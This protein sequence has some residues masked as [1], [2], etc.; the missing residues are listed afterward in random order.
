MSVSVEAI[1][2]GRQ[3]VQE[4]VDEGRPLPEVLETLCLEVERAAGSGVLA[5]VLL[6]DDDRLH[7][8]HGAAPSLPDAYNE[9]IDGIEIGA[10]VGSCGTAVYR[11]EPVIVTDISRDP[12]WADF[13][14]LA[15]EHGLGACWST[16]IKSS[17]GF[18]LGTFA[19]YYPEP[20]QPQPGDRAL[21]AAI[22]DIAARA[23]EQQRGD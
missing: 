9:A 6:L 10:S 11:R 4:L 22:A 17:R 8:R 23:I 14:D 21:V 1:E 12:L 2:P 18:I 13:K 15:A 7:L 20:R 16:P 3:R 5:S 19:M